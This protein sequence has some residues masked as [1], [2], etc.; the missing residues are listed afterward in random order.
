MKKVLLTLSIFFLCATALQAQKIGYINTETILNK[1]PEYQ[2]AQTQLNTLADNFKAGIEKAISE[3]DALYIAYQAQKSSL[4]ASQREIK[5]NEIITKERTVKE[6]QNL[7]FGEDGIMTHKSKELLD[8]IHAKINAAIETLTISGD[9][10]IIID[11][12]VT[13][14]VIYKNAKYDLTQDIITLLNI[15]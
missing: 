1:M 12:A 6:K 14:G 2:A 11:M 9:Y 10:A 7:Y 5:E 8:P 4:S 15:K 3:I 13:P